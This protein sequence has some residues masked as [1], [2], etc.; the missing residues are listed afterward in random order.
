MCACK[1]AGAHAHDASPQDALVIGS[2]LD[3]DAAGE[4]CRL[5]FCGRLTALLDPAAPHQ[6][7]RLRVYKVSIAPSS[8][9][10]SM[11]FRVYHAVGMPAL[12]R[13]PA[14]HGIA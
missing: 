13:A 8:S 14:G 5:A 6:L 2:R 3:A 12:T 10:T 9:P 7:E 11:T 1:P 4:S